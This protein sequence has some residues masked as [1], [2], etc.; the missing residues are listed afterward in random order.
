MN[1]TTF[2]ADAASLAEAIM[3]ARVIADLSGSEADRTH[4]LAL[5]FLKSGN[6]VLTIEV[7][8]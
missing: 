2:R 5:A 6:T 7:L 3:D 8:S 4:A 1:K